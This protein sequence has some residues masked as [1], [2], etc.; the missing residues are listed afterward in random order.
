MVVVIAVATVVVVVINNVLSVVASN[1]STIAMSFCCFYC[2]CSTPRY[3]KLNLY[4]TQYNIHKF[5]ILL[6]FYMIGKFRAV[7]DISISPIEASDQELIIKM[8]DEPDGVTHI[9]FN[10]FTNLAQFQKVRSFRYST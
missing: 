8:M 4:S 1:I 9:R 6:Y 7:R 3:I 10:N 2:C 5:I